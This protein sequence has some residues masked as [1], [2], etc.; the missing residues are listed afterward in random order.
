LFCQ[1]LILIPFFLFHEKKTVYLFII[2]IK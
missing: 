1:L 2:F